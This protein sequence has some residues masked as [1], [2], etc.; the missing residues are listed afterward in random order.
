MSNDGATWRSKV[1]INVAIV[2]AE[3]A[4]VITMGAVLLDAAARVL[5]V[6]MSCKRLQKSKRNLL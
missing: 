1:A 6:R 4:G 5:P 2:G 3:D